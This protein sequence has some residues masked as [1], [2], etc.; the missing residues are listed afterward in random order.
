MENP[1]PLARLH[2]E[3]AH[4]AL[5]VAHRLRDMARSMG[6]ADD[7]DVARDERRGIQAELRGDGI[8]IL[9]VVLL[10]IHDAGTAE[11]RNRHA[12]PGVQRDHPVAGRHV[13][14]ALIRSVSARPVGDAPARAGARGVLAAD[15][16][17]LGVHPE[18]L[19]GRGIERHDSTPGARRGVEHAADHQRCRR[20]QVV[21]PRPERIR[22]EPPGDLQLRK[23][24]PVDL[25]E[26]RVARAGEVAAVRRPFDG[27]RRFLTLTAGARPVERKSDRQHRQAGGGP[28]SRTSTAMLLPQNH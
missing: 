2:V 1:Q 16:F 13:N 20:I 27:R 23:I 22:I 9:I 28:E 25:V 6:R 14:D 24:L 7:H 3:A 18:Q 15:A 17:V 10:Q 5:R 26:R 8:E 12:G 19:P 21:G 11:G 4:V